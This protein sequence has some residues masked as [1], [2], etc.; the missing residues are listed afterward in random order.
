MRS[1]ADTIPI[2]G[3]LSLVPLAISNAASSTFGFLIE[4]P[5][6]VWMDVAED[7]ADEDELWISLVEL[8]ALF[9]LSR[10]LVLLGAWPGF[11]L[12]VL[13]EERELED[14]V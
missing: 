12:R 7:M 11:S 10:E 8:W 3:L 1:S 9:A 6:G 2:L 4:G 13:S 14:K 5:V